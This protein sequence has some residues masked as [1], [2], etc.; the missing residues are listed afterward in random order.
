MDSINRTFSWNAQ[1]TVIND[2]LLKRVDSA[3]TAFKLFR[4][5]DSALKVELSL[6]Q[7]SIVDRDTI[8]AQQQRVIHHREQQ[9]IRLK[10]HKGI[11]AIFDAILIGVIGYLVIFK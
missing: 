10:W 3:Q 7:L 4:Q 11:L 1:L 8:I 5:S 9:V 2:S 6:K